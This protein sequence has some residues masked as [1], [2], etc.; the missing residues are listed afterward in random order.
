M[1][2]TDPKPLTV[3]ELIEKLQDLPPHLPVRIAFDSNVRMD[4]ERIIQYNQGECV[5]IT[6]DEEFNIRE[7]WT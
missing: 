7:S 5:V 4:A 3:A 6:D 1:R 2:L